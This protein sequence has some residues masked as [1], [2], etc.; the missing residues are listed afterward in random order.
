MIPWFLFFVFNSAFASPTFSSINDSIFKPS[1]VTCHSGAEPKG[2]VDLTSYE[3]LMASGSVVKGKPFESKLYLVVDSGD[4]PPEGAS[5]PS[6]LVDDI[7]KW[8]KEGANAN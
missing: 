5:I 8:I 3:K 2:K 4:M 1:C 6:S 7:Y